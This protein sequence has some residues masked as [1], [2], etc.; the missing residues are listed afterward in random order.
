M[1]LLKPFVFLLAAIC[2][3]GVYAQ[4]AYLSEE[5]EKAQTSLI[6]Y[7]RLKK[8]SPSIDPSDQSVC[9]K[10]GDILYWVT[11]DGNTSPLLYTLHRRPIR[12]GN[13]E[14][15]DISRRREVAEKA[16]NMVCA[17]RTVKA[18]LN[19]NKVEFCFPIYAATPEDFQQVFS[20]ALAAFKNIKKSFDTNYAKARVK[21]DSIHNYWC[22]LDTTIVV[23]KQNNQSTVRTQ[24]MLDIQS[25]SV[26]VVDDDGSV[27]SDYDKGIRKSSCEF[28]QERIEVT[29]QKAGVYKIGVKLYDPNGKLLVP[30]ENARFTTIT[31][32]E[33][34]KAGKAEIHELL[35]FGSQDKDIWQAG[36]YKVKFYED[37]T[38]IFSDAINIL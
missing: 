35:K 38:E 37:D 32:I 14:D 30:D 24:K 5:Q 36:E 7:L 12:F 9:F 34:K 28:L 26:R 18:F 6:K 13:N 8:Y 29:A 4:R 3:L 21:V 10:S 19:N 33:I 20:S 17:E 23:V 16:A 25:I 1:K 27:I 31:T 22:N 15:K 2:S 11:F